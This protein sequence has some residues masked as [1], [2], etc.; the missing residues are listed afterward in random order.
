MTDQENDVDKDDPLPDDFNPENAGACRAW[1]CKCTKFVYQN[2]SR[3]CGNPNC[4]HSNQRH[5]YTAA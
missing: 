3:K 5:E 2:G 1:G 4:S